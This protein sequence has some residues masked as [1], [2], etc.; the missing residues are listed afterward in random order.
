M[1]R[2]AR[3]TT[4]SLQSTTFVYYSVLHYCVLI[5]FHVISCRI[6]S[7]LIYIASHDIAFIEFLS[8]MCDSAL[9]NVLT[10]SNAN[11]NTNPDI[12]THTNAHMRMRASSLHCD[13]AF[14]NEQAASSVRALDGGGAARELSRSWRLG[15]VRSAGDRFHIEFSF[16]ME[17]S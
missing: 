15:N 6:T 17:Y 13:D 1:T 14:G 3:P 7:M 5:L 11:T 4:S 12:N 8:M 9:N 10:S 2:D 16:P